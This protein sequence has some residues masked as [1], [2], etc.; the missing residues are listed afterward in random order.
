MPKLIIDDRRIEVPS[1]TKVIEAAATLGIMIPRFCYHPALGSVG[2]CRV[3]AV[4]VLEGP[5]IGIHMSCMLDAADGMKISTTDKETVDFRRYVIE[6]LMMNHPHDC[7]V[8]DEGGHCLLQDMT[9]SGGHG[10]R[11]FLGRKR[12]YPDQHLGPLVQHEMNRCI[13]CYRCSRYYQEFSGYR[14]LGALRLGDRTYFG[15]TESGVLE[16]PFAGNLSDICPTGV[17]TD[18]PSRFFGR[19]WDYQRTPTLCINCSLGCHAVTSVRFRQAVRQE[20]RFSAAVNGWFICDRGRY[21]FFYA[22]LSGR[23]RQAAVKGETTALD[24]AAANARSR[25]E[26]FPADAVAVIGSS[27]S[28]LETLA[29]AARTARRNGW[30]GPAFFA[31]R[32][33]TRKMKTVAARL[34]P[35]LAVSLRDIEAADVIVAVGADPVN[36]APMLAMALRQA[37]RRG[38]GVVVLDPRPVFLPFGF[39]HIPAAP[40][41]LA[42]TLGMILKKSISPAGLDGAAAK[43]HASLP[44]NEAAGPQA[45]AEA[46]SRLAGSRRPVIVCGT[47]VTTDG[48]LQAAADAVLLLAADRRAAGLF[49]LLPGANAF[50][51]G[52]INGRD[53]GMSGLLKDAAAGMLKALI[54]VETDPFASFPD[55]RLLEQALSK[56]ELLVVLDYIDSPAARRAHVFLPTQTIYEA[57]GYFVNQEGRIQATHRVYPGGIPITQ[58]GGGD[59]PPRIYGAGPAGSDPQPAWRVMARLSGEEL[60]EGSDACAD[61]LRCWIVENVPGLDHLPPLE[62]MPPEGF[63][64]AAPDVSVESAAAPQAKSADAVRPDA[65]E[66]VLT[67]RTFGAEELSAYSTCLEGLQEKPWA[68]F[69]QQD[70]VAL[71]IGDGDRVAIHTESGAV[72]LNARLYDRMA[73]GV[74]VVPRLRGVDWQ[75]LGKRVRRR[76]VRKL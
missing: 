38:A 61:L 51:A 28:S 68:A 10:I 9:V 58:T 22:S 46:A 56:L 36:E 75:S 20:A 37:A 29:M 48:D 16:S 55:R 69:Q 60:P 13:H 12:T 44:G 21:G 62:K 50:G 71:G 47:D 54:L 5:V 19:R 76:D 26:A 3:C 40:A 72:E 73:P 63:R 17:Y 49:Y 42:T 66:I 59:H 14:D 25:L 11:R 45:L 6:W 52:L 65:L 34:A 24:E 31:D 2:A 33:S 35:H 41:A 30:Q 15:R 8:C 18:K 39:M 7:P 70:A 64:I 27:R 4:K 53:D 57:G 67:D 23:P 74:M 1:G 32:D 43:F